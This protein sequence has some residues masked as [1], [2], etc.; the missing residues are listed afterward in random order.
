MAGTPI[1]HIKIDRVAG[2]KPSHNFSKRLG[3]AQYQQMKMIW[4]QT[5]GQAS[6][7]GSFKGDFKAG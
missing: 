7:S 6:A 4:H 3:A 5:P 1:P 2:H